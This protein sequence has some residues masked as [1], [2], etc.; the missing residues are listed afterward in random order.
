MAARLTEM[1][2]AEGP[3]KMRD[4]LRVG[5]K[6]A[7]VGT[8]RSGI[9]ITERRRAETERDRLRQQLDRAQKMDTLERL[10][11]K[12][13]ELPA[14]FFLATRGRPRFRMVSPPGLEPGTVGL[15]EPDEPEE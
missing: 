10:D 2:A 9:D 14:E 3:A 8:L 4:T 13:L 12:P 6:G 1:N 15:K 5:S 11:L 7:P